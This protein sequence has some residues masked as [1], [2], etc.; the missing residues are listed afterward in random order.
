M[1]ITKYGHCC[2]LLEIDGVKILTD[3]GSYTTEQNAVTGLDAV[4]I[5]HSHQDHYH[6]ESIPKIKEN[7]PTAVFVTNAEVGQHL[8]KE[9]I[10]FAK[11]G[12]GESTEIKGVLVEGFGKDHA[13]I[14][15]TVGLVENTAY[16]IGEKFYFPGDNFHLP[17]KP[18]EVLALPIAG[19]WMK[20]S[21]AVDFAKAIGAKHAFGVHDRIIMPNSR[22]FIG[23][24]M[25]NL[26][27]NTAYQVIPDG[28]TIE[29]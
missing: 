17:N 6:A 12:E 27:Q 29:F 11:V 4:L 3:P 5:T 24:L 1:R 2:I 23:I 15:G 8:A 19:P 21:E 26:L 18:V 7:N 22:G 20:I 28:E 16:R 25:T 9:N 13:P 10:E 14:Y